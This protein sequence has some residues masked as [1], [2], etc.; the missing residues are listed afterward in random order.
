MCCYD[1][2][3]R[4]AVDFACSPMVAIWEVTL[5]RAFVVADMVFAEN[6]ACIYEP[7]LRA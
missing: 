7:P 5:A 4:S 2:C 3:M 1:V 6:P